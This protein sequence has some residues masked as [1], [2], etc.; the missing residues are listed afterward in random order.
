[1][2][3]LTIITFFFLICASII[4]AQTENRH[5]NSDPEKAGFVTSDIDNFWRAFDLANKET[6]RKRKIAVY[7]REYLDKGSAGLKDFVR[8]RIKTAENLYDTIEKLPRFYASVR[9]LILR[10]REMEK[11]MRKS[12]RRFKQIYSDA[13]FPDVYFVIGVANTGGTASENGLLIGTELYGLTD[14]TPRDEFIELFRNFKPNAKD[15]RELRLLAAK[16]T[17][18]ALKPIEG[19]P[20]IVAHESCHFNQKYPALDTLLA[21]ALQEGA[22]DF[23]GEKI[24]GE[25]MNPA[26]KTY[27]EKHEAELWREFQAEM[28][29]KNEKNWMYNALTVKTRPPDLG[30]F[31]GYKISR[32]FYKNARDKRQAIR[33]ILQIKDFPAF[34]QQSLYLQ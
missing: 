28:N 3:R 34:L 16:Y 1:M 19:I 22:C 20:A 21:K 5:L 33:D 11:R 13:L 10:V 27:G 15:E 9:P 4:F 18:V 14:K 6:E 12:F 29:G 17:D 30:Y 25:L 26:Q 31:I 23:I 7:Q 24:S 8:M 2:K 32:S